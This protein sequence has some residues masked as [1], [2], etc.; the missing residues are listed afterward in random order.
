M[1][2]LMKVPMRRRIGATVVAPDGEPAIVWCYT[3]RVDWLAEFDDDDPDDV[4]EIRALH[5][6]RDG[7]LLE[8]IGEHESRDLEVLELHEIHRPGVRDCTKRNAHVWPA[9][10]TPDAECQRCALPYREFTACNRR[11]G[12]RNE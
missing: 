9:E 5:L 12:D 8:P 10:L 11:E 3:S 6:W 7:R 2:K 4:A 1:Q